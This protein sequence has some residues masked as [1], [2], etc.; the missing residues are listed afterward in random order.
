VFQVAFG[1]GPINNY[2]FVLWL[3]AGMIPWFFFS[4]SLANATGSIVDYS[5]IVKKIVFRVSMLPLIKILSSLVVHLFF[6][7]L[8]IVL[9]L[10]YGYKPALSWIQVFYYMGATMLFVMG[11]SWVTSSIAVFI[12]DVRQ[13]I[14]MLLQIG[15]WITP[16]F[17]NFRLV[18][19][20]YV[21][22]CKANPAYYIVE[23]YRE[24]FL[25]HVWFW[26]HPLRM[27]Y[28]WGVTFVIIIIG[29]LLFLRLR[30]HFADV[31]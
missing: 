10:L 22:L 25:T 30:P 17:W 5:Y 1:S 26:E 12:R 13:I 28:F 18:P 3:C 20:K 6:V 29:A 15:F 14:A 4:E 11:L 9:L 31:L 19:Q 8:I 21:L 7:L 27:L 24:C 16:I 2:P 23:G